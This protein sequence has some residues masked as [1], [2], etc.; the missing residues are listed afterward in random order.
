MRHSKD[1]P[2]T[3]T[4]VTHNPVRIINLLTVAHRNGDA[5]GAI[6][7]GFIYF[8]GIGVEVHFPPLV[9]PLMA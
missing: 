7:F 8:K 2:V 1:V 5:N 9:M 3:N 4:S 6:G